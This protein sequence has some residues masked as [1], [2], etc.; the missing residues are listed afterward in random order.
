MRQEF[1]E[2]FLHSRTVPSAPL[3]FYLRVRL[4]WSAKCGRTHP[5]RAGRRTL[6]LGAY[7]HSGANTMLTQ[8]T[9]RIA[10]LLFGTAAVAL[11]IPAQAEW[12]GG[13]GGTPTPSS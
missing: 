11:A 13:Y 6:P 4:L 10:V 2:A 5:R 8:T 9:S 12:G 1:E 7:P 3:W